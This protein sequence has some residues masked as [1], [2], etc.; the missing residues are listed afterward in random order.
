LVAH[1]GRPTRANSTGTSW[2]GTAGSGDVLSGL[3]GTYLAAGLDPR[4]AGSMAAFIHGV[5]GQ[6]LS[7]G[8]ISPL[9]SRELADA[10]PDA[11]AAIRGSR[12]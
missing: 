10:L 2:L 6:L 3:A 9:R 8:E 4:E 11:V 7:K 12:T 1:A 5:A